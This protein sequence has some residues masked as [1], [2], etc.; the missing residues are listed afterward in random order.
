MNYSSHSFSIMCGLGQIPVFFLCV[1]DSLIKWGKF[2]FVFLPCG[3]FIKIRRNFCIKSR[4]STANIVLSWVPKSW[5]KFSKEM[6]E[7]GAYQFRILLF[8]FTFF[9]PPQYDR[10]FQKHFLVKV[11]K[12]CSSYLAYISS[13]I[14][15]WMLCDRDV[16]FHHVFYW[17]IILLALFIKV[18]SLLLIC[19]ATTFLYKIPYILGFFLGFLFNFIIKLLCLCAYP[20]TLL[21]LLVL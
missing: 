3:S 12:F 21:T 14:Y 9:V 6:S 8:F 13:G 10:N 11:E 17:Q 15:L 5:R 19:K 2:C 16:I 1:S 20:H 4:F 7:N 18:H